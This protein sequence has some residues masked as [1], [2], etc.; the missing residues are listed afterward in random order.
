MSFE[1]LY[2]KYFSRIYSYILYRVISP[3]LADDMVSLVFEKILDKYAGFDPAKAVIIEAWIFA[4][5]RNT[6]NDHFRRKK[7]LTWL[8]MSGMEDHIKSGESVENDAEKHEL[9]GKVLKAVEQLSNQEREIIALKFT[10]AMTNRAIADTTGLGESNVGVILFRAMRKLKE[11][12]GP[13]A[14]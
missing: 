13:E 3:D 9:A 1:E 8:S 12:L 6:L 2:E 14:L 5:A 4:I 10:L 7:I 11:L